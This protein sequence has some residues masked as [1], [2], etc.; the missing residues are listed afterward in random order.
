[1]S[2]PWG[3]GV[4]EGHQGQWASVRDDANIE[5]AAA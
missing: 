2:S 4:A 1:M 3:C 5:Y